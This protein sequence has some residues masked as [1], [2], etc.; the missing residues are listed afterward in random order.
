MKHIKITQRMLDKSIIDAN[1]AVKSFVDENLPL[2]YDNITAPLS[3]VVYPAYIGY[4]YPRN[5]WSGSSLR[6]Y[7]RPRGD[8]LLSIGNL[9]KFAEA[10]DYIR[11]E[12][13]EK[14]FLDYELDKTNAKFMRSYYNWSEAEW[15]PDPTPQPDHINYQQTVVNITVLKEGAE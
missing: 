7:R 1:K 3:K 10:G 2:R 15:M 13:S 6:I 5:E 14:S 9:A 4:G 12:V 11:L 8:A